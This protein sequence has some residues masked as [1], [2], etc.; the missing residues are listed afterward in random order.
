MV[1]AP[2]PRF[3]DLAAE[4]PPG[5]FARVGRPDGSEYLRW[6]DLFEFLISPDGSRIEGRALEKASDESFQTYLLAQVLSFALLK[7]GVEPLH[8]TTVVVNERAIA[9]AAMPGRGKS[10]LGAALLGAGARMLTD[11]A[12]VLQ[13]SDEGYM[14]QPSVPRIKLFPAT[15]RVLLGAD[16]SGVAMN[17]DTPKMIIPLDEARFCDEPMPLQTIY[18]LADT[19]RAEKVWTRRM[20]ARRAFVALTRHTFNSV[21]VDEGRLRQ[22]FAF[23]TDVASAVPVKALSYPRGLDELPAVCDAILED[24]TA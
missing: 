17:E 13:P 3:A 24:T 1:W 8:A 6:T 23:A 9:F 18:V 11:D 2:A 20:S 5:W 16:A 4:A 15:A 10:T 12:L 19:S 14:A 21:V 7:K 22:Q